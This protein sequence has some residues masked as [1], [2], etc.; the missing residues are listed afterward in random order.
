MLRDVLHILAGILL[1]L[2]DFVE[3]ALDSLQIPLLAHI[4]LADDLHQLPIYEEG[5]PWGETALNIEIKND[6]TKEGC[7]ED[8][9]LEDYHRETHHVPVQA[10]GDDLAFNLIRYK[11]TTIR[12]SNKMWILGDINKTAIYYIDTYIT[13]IYK[14]T[15]RMH[16]F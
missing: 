4:L 10:V 5:T 7:S 3:L 6:V 12:E 16:S 11:V 9:A 13:Q 15:S 2:R 8:L 14:W 1:V